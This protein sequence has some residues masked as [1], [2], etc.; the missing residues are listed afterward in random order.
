MQAIEKYEHEGVPVKIYQDEDPSSPREWS[1]IGE[2]VCW[3]RGYD[4]GD[5]QPESREI[6]ALERGG[7][8]LLERYLK[9][10]Q[11]ATVVIPL[12]LIDHS[13]ISMYAGGGEHRC[14]PGGWDS[15]TVGFIFDTPEG[16]E[17]CGTTPEYVETC[18]LQEIE[19]YNQYLRGD[20]YGYVVAD[21]REDEDSCWGFFGIEDVQ[22]EA[23]SIAEIIAKERAELRKLPWLPTF[24][25][26]I[27]TSAPA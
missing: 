13:G 6:K 16:R 3:H 20:V 11:G 27:H 10:M 22:Q 2:M 23:N 8:R 24:G 1:N 25:N 17:E 26:P 21:G 7:R 15:G 14:D 9:M 18:L 12:G 5:R 19:V 4:L